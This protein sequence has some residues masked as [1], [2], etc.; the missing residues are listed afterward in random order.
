MIKNSNIQKS[1]VISKELN[2]KLNAEAKKEYF[3]TTSQL[4]R[5]ILSDYIRDKDANK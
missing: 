5:K 4:I 3:G 2:D 1:I